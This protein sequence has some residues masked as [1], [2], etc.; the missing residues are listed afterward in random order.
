MPWRCRS[1][2]PLPGSARG[3]FKAPPCRLLPGGGF[4]T[5]TESWGG[6]GLASKQPQPIPKA[7]HTEKQAQ[8]ARGPAVVPLSPASLSQ[9]GQWGPWG[10]QVGAT[11]RGGGWAPS[12]VKTGHLEPLFRARGWP[13]SVR[14]TG[15]RGW[16]MLPGRGHTWQVPRAGPKSRSSRAEGGDSRCSARRAKAF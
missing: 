15:A 1:P 3:R 2:P 4:H 5:H 14:C 9:G 10:P 13:L 8:G 11:R 7:P 12:P 16:V 6:G